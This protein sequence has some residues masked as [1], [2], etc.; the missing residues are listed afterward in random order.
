MARGAREIPRGVGAGFP[1]RVR[2][3]VVA[4]QTGLAD[5]GWL[6]FFEFLDLALGIV[7]DV[8]LARTM[9][10]LAAERGGRRARVLDLPVPRVRHALFLRLVTHDAGIGAGV[11]RRQRGRRSLRGGRLGRSLLRRWLSAPVAAAHSPASHRRDGPRSR[12]T[13]R[14]A[15]IRKGAYSDSRRLP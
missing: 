5:F 15:R 2:P 11:A 14:S 9:A 3:A 8:R 10:A 6:E 13:R 12:R 4:G 1:A 7:V